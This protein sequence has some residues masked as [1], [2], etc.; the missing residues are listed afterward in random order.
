IDGPYADDCASENWTLDRYFSP[1]QCPSG[2]KTCTLPTLTQRVVTTEICCSSGLDCMFQDYCAKIFNDPSPIIY[3][4]ST[5]SSQTSVWGV[6]ASAVQIRFQKSDSTVVPIPTASFKLP[7]PKKE[8]DVKDQ[9]WNWNWN[10]CG[11]Y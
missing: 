1:G 2:Y 5:I 8:F 9:S 10:W 3:S 7:G 6:T 11:C 4:D